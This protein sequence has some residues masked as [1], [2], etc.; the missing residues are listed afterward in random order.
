LL[1]FV[2]AFMGYYKTGAY[3]IEGGAQRL[4]DALAASFCD[5]G[6][7][8]QSCADVTQITLEAGAATGVVCDVGGVR[9]S[10]AAGTVISAADATHTFRDLVGEAHLPA[11]FVA[12]LAALR[13]AISVF[14]VYLGVEMDLPGEVAEDFEIIVS[15]STTDADAVFERMLRRERFDDMAITLYSNIDASMSPAPGRKH[16]I[17]LLSIMNMNEET[18]ERDWDASDIAQRGEAYRARKQHYAEQLIDSAERVIPGLRAGIEVISIATPLTM[19][20]YTRNR[21][22]SILGWDNSTEQ[23]MMRRLKQRTP[24][25]NLFL[26]GAWTF[27]GGGINGASLSG[28][29]LADQILEAG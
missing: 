18:L 2:M 22:G 10:Y 5:H 26:A 15:S 21:N 24:I 20:R 7:T 13:P 3:H 25:A 4:S 1:F 29:T 19:K 9:Q 16:T 8:L 23:S 28:A 27:P 6:G 11:T 14:A 17:S 12:E